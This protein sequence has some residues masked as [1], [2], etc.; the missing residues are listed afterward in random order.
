MGWGWFIVNWF[1]VWGEFYLQTNIYRRSKH[2]L[3][4]TLD[5]ALTSGAIISTIVTVPFDFLVNIRSLVHSTAQNNIFV[6]AGDIT[7]HQEAN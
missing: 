5:F 1:C 3:R 6:V 7:W 4:F 2:L